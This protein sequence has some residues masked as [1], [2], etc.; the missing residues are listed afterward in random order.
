MDQDGKSA[1]NVCCER[2]NADEGTKDQ[3]ISM[4]KGY[5]R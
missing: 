3:I 1:A 2:V 4:I 5:S